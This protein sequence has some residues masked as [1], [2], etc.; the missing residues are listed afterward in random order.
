MGNTTPWGA[1][2]LEV[3]VTIYRDMDLGKGEL[4][5]PTA[6]RSLGR[7]KGPPYWCPEQCWTGEQLCSQSPGGKLSQAVGR[8]GSP[9]GREVIV[10]LGI[11]GAGML[12]PGFHCPPTHKMLIM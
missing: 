12:S 1:E 5:D 6:G 3:R 8:E 10:P 9:W 7:N 4:Q 11:W 2:K